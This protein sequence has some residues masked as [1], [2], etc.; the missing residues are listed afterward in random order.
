MEVV[1]LTEDLEPE[2]DEFIH[3]DP[4]STFYHQV[5]WKRVIQ[6]SYGHE[7][8]YLI[9]KDSDAI[10]GVLPMFLMKNRLFGKKLVSIPFGSY[11]GICGKKDAKERILNRAYNIFK[12]KNVDYLELRGFS[13]IEDMAY[14][15]RYFTLIL[16]LGDEE[17]IWNGFNK[18]VRNSTRKAY[19][20]G[21]K[22]DVGDEYLND[23]FQLYSQNMHD[24]GTPTHSIHFFEKLISEFPE[25][26]VCVVQKD[27]N[28]IAA[29]ILFFYNDTVTSGWAASDMNYLKYCPNNILYWEAIKKHCDNYKYFD[30][31]R[32]L[33]DSGTFRFKKKWNA[34]EK[35]LYYNYFTK[36]K[37]PDTSKTNQKR[38]TFSKIWTKLPI[39]LTN[40]LGPRL[41]KNFP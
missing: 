17:E 6:E 4:E 35:Q 8:I 13:K 1:K 7:P 15:D 40:K 2:W 9:S 24:L 18:K 33:K 30:F 14:S 23:F 22:F 26:E 41:R 36:K 19:K 34:K 5:G 31:G 25:T 20:S 32:S 27:N 12:E 10:S 29:M 38:K 16:N 21:L 28:C 3:Q 37:L 11:G 39:S